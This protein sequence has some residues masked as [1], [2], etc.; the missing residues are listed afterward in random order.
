M[1]C[2]ACGS[3]D[4][5][6]SKGKCHECLWVYEQEQLKKRLKDPEKRKEFMERFD[7]L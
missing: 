1:K 4:V 3:D 5:T 6:K 7:R 2:K